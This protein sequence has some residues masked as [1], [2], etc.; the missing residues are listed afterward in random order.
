MAL[1]KQATSSDGKTYDIGSEKGL[2][3]VNNASAGST[4]TGGDGST[5]TKNADGSTTISKNGSTY[6][7]GG[8]GG[9][10]STSSGSSGGGGG[11]SRN[12]SPTVSNASTA[13]K[14][15]N[16]A[17]S[18]GGGG[19]SSGG[20]AGYVYT[21]R[22]TYN[23]ADIRASG[24]AD[25]ITTYK[26]MWDAAYARDDKDAMDQAHAMA[27]AYRAQFGYS[28][29]GDGSENIAVPVS[30]GWGGLGGAGGMQGGI[31]D[32][33]WENGAVALGANGEQ[34]T[35]GSFLGKNFLF[36]GE[37]GETM[38]GGDG[39]IW[40][41][42]PDGVVTITKDGKTYTVQ[43]T[44]KE[45]LE[46]FQMPDFQMPEAFE[47]GEFSY[48]PFEDTALGRQAMA[49]YQ[50]LLDQVNNYKA[51]S[52]DKDTDP[53]YQQYADSYTRSGQ[54][55]MNDVLGQLAART[56]GMAS[57]YAGAMA[58]QTYDQY[59]ADLANKVP[60]LQQLA[61]SMYMDDY[62]KLL[63]RY[64][65]GYQRYAD[66]YNRYMD[67]ARLDQNT[68]AT[69]AQLDQ[70]TWSQMANMAMDQ[71]QTQ[72]QMGYNQW[73]DR[74]ADRQ[75]DRQN[76]QDVLRTDMDYKANDRNFDY[77]KQQDQRNFDYQKEQDQWNRQYAER[78]LANSQRS[79]LYD[80]VAQ[81]Y[82]P[83]Q[84]DAARLGLSPAELAALQRQA[85]NL[86]GSRS[87]KWWA[88]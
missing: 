12:T 35:I 10:G 66:D 60:E 77:Q 61:Y 25:P 50:K 30:G 53:L 70:N 23:D 51:F 62:N 18:S 59:M 29:G 78:E 56:G 43:G 45:P 40:T 24:L 54:R 76:T 34:Y 3:F 16:A 26:A 88:Y 32:P 37:N 2:D 69:K 83:T 39:S 13:V 55:A 72:A 20:P 11:S 44:P 42:G 65:R 64:D 86:W 7:V 82:V 15:A 47:A 71:W 58:Q 73:R 5:W 63:G 49:D 1:K 9:S 4:M 79:E 41:K 46:E 48:T 31:A 87:D 19:R 8:G 67:K 52:Y 84:E 75:F 74:V 36:N 17:I 57:S 21:P 38:R 28:G 14:N 81:G 6:R 33:S 22:G 80:R 85:N 27:E 68:W